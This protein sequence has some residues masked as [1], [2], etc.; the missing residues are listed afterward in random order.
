MTRPA[1]LS[2]PPALHHVRDLVMVTLAATLTGLTDWPSIADF[3]HENADWMKGRLIGLPAGL[4]TQTVFTQV[5]GR[6]DP[7]A[8]AHALGAWN[9]AGR[10]LKGRAGS[11][12]MTASADERQWALDATADASGD[13]DELIALLDLKGALVSVHAC[14]SEPAIADAIQRQGGHYIL[15]LRDDPMRPALLEDVRQWLNYCDAVHSGQ[16]AD[17]TTLL[18]GHTASV[19]VVVSSDIDWLIDK[20]DWPALQAVARLT[21]THIAGGQPVTEHQHV[22]CSMAEPRRILEMA[23][24]GGLL[25]GRLVDIQFPDRTDLANGMT[26]LATVRRLALQI[27]GQ[28]TVHPDLN[29]RRRMMRAQSDP[30]YLQTLLRS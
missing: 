7:V 28:D 23:L 18:P 10:P 14:G 5:I 29:V 25:P 16:V 13:I 27:L 17:H 15:A 30:V 20:P 2:V 3:A 4:P 1:G 9:L 22:L 12:L 26:N 6:M 11:P 24:P 21:T 8:F 19:Q